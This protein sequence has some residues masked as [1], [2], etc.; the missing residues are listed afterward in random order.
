[1]TE[2]HYQEIAELPLTLD[3]VT[4]HLVQNLHLRWG[5]GLLYVDRYIGENNEP[6]HVVYGIRKPN[7]ENLY[8]LRVVLSTERKST[9]IEINLWR[10]VHKGWPFQNQEGKVVI[11]VD[12]LQGHQTAFEQITRD[13]LKFCETPHGQGSGVMDKLRNLFGKGGEKRKY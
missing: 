5:Y 4:Q 7:D 12:I 8:G 10:M 13:I 11:G 3:D 6:V 2:V 9:M 1:M